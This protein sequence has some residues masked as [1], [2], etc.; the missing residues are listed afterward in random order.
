MIDIVFV[1][2]GVFGI[3]CGAF[4]IKQHIDYLRVHTIIEKQQQQIVVLSRKMMK[5]DLGLSSK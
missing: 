1:C 3:I 4:G 2:A 5:R